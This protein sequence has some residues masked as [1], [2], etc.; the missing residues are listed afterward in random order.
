MIQLRALVAAG[1]ACFGGLMRQF[2]A[3]PSAVLELDGVTKLFGNFAAVRNLSFSVPPG[4]VFGFLG[5]NGAGKTTTLRMV[6]DIFR[7]TSGSI[8]VLGADS[9]FKVRRRLGYLPE[10]KGLYK[11]M[12]ACSVIAYLATLKGLDMSAARKRARALLD[13]YGLGAV[14]NTRIEALSKGMAQKVQVLAAIAHEPEL[15]I[16]DEP[17]SG[18]DPVNQA[19]L[20]E[21]LADLKSRGISI[22]FS[23]HVMQHAERLCDRLLILARGQKVF[24]GT[25]REAKRTQPLK[26][27]LHSDDDAAFLEGVAGVAAVRSTEPGYW[28]ADLKP[29]ADPQCVLDAC[30]T[31]HVRL[32]SYH[33]EEPSLHDIFVSLVGLDAREAR[34]NA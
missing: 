28:E 27:R 7:P 25:L 16:F 9:A 18:L 10:E 30:Y 31:R 3:V 23:T 19:V 13:K 5:P 8:R 14:A 26:V 6:L 29:D 11:K 20:E 4:R 22:V 21:M 24:E 12:K 17:F 34:E 33:A 2:L 1:I 15:I 32:K